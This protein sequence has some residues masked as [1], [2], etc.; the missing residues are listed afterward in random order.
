MS[1]IATSL[2]TSD[3]LGWQQYLKRLGASGFLRISPQQGNTCGNTS[4]LAAEG[5][6]VGWQN[7]GGISRSTGSTGGRADPQDFGTGS[8]VVRQIAS[9]LMQGRPSLADTLQEL[10][11]PLSLSANHIT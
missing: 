2:G 10:G 4:S 9:S 8:R 3:R 7:G 6:G 1:I 11:P 5:G